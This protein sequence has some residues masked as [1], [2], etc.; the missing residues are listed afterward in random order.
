MI[1]PAHQKKESQGLL[2]AEQV[3][4][5]K[6]ITTDDLNELYVFHKPGLIENAERGFGREGYVSG[7]GANLSNSEGVSL[8][9]Y[10]IQTGLHRDYSPDEMIAFGRLDKDTSGLMVLARRNCYPRFMD[11][12]LLNPLWKKAS[13]T[14]SKLYR[15]KVKGIVNKADLSKIKTL[16]IPSKNETLVEVKVESMRLISV[17]VSDYE[18]H[19]SIVEVEIHEGMHHQVKKMFYELG[20]PVRKGGLHRVRFAM[21]TLAAKPGAALPEMK[22]G[23]IRKLF[24][25]EKEQLVKLYNDWLSSERK[26]LHI[27]S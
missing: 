20:H 10:F 11:Q 1:S 13:V 3:E 22:V 19:S 9:D 4:P 17:E 18:Q 23:Q 12:L 26:R 15:A 8:R 16:Q 2:L 7:F 5:L 14:T 21:L 6:D 27:Q 24:A 25:S